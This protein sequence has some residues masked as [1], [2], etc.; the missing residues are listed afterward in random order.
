MHLTLLRRHWKKPVVRLACAVFLL[1]T[2]GVLVQDRPN[3]HT[4]GYGGSGL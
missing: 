4:G 1:F 2:G 3:Q